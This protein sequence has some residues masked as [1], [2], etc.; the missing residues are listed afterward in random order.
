MKKITSAEEL[1]NE[2]GRKSAEIKLNGKVLLLKEMSA[3]DRL[4]FIEFHAEHKDQT[5]LCY[6]FA[7]TRCCDVMKDTTPQEIVDKLKPD[8]LIQIGVKIQQIS[9]MLRSP[10][11]K[12]A[13]KD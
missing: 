2:N 12:E 5:E 10:K 11:G 8:V 13:K 7:L 3:L 9:G 6:A 1:F 4:D